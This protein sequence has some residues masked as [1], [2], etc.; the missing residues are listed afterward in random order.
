VVKV[1]DLTTKDTKN[2]EKKERMF[3]AKTQNTQRKDC[4]ASSEW[5]V[6]SSEEK[7]KRKLTTE[8][9]GESHR[10]KTNSPLPGQKA[11]RTRRTLRK[12]NGTRIKTDFGD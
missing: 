2:H 1:K 7:Y 11:P 8:E 6:R 10:K 9:H 12:D 3:T 5:K 4:F